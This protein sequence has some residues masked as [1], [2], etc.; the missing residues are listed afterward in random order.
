MAFWGDYHTHTVYSHGKGCIEDNV[1][2]AAKL[3]LKEIAVAD[4]GFNH[5]VFNLRRSELPDMRRQ[6]ENLKIKYPSITVYLSVESNLLDRQGHI[7][8]KPDDWKSLDMAVCGFH[9]LVF[10][11]PKSAAFFAA[12]LV[13]AS[14]AK[15]VARNTDAY[16][17]A[18][19]KNDIDIL[20]HPG[21]FCKCDIRAVAQACRARGTYFELN[22][23]RIH[24]SDEELAAAA[25]EDVEFVCSSDAHTPKRVGDFSVAV[26]AIERV[27]IPYESVSNYERLPKFRSRENE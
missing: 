8:I 23:K 20:S 25:A 16:V 2:R 21:N 6:I 10:A 17:N 4:H 22:G 1:L 26:A 3:G 13:G 24:L 19:L 18:V 7:D 14:S 12:N 5:I 15:T 27:G 11:P 9:K